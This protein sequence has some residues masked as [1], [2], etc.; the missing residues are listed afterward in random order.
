MAVAGTQPISYLPVCR[1]GT[2]RQ[3]E[4]AAYMS[5][6]F[7]VFSLKLIMKQDRRLNQIFYSKRKDALL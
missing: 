5:Y 6:L 3:S 2:G 7:H 4:F 1:V